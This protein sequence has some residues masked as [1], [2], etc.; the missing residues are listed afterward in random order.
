[1]FAFLRSF[2]TTVRKELPRIG[3]WGGDLRGWDWDI[4]RG[5]VLVDVVAALRR[6]G[7]VLAER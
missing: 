3:C 5:C 1:M 2:P 7:V 4:A 6:Y